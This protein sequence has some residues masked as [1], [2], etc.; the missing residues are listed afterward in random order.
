MGA[1]VGRDAGAGTGLPTLAVSLHSQLEA[2]IAAA[3]GSPE[4]FS[5]ENG[6]SRLGVGAADS[7]DK[8][9]LGSMVGSSCAIGTEDATTEG[10]VG[11][12]NG[13]AETSSMFTGVESGGPAIG[14][15]GTTS[16]AYA[17]GELDGVNWSGIGGVPRMGR[18][19]REEGGESEVC[20][21]LRWRIE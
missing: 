18:E 20:T 19:C 16:N 8:T 3:N 2:S 13:T 17:R 12:G 1:G 11:G 21:N 14:R 15:G 5:N 6:A 7:L 4:S 9:A 10:E